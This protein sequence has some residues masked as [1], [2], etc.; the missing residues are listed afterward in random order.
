MLERLCAELFYAAAEYLDDEELTW[1]SH[2]APWVRA[3]LDPRTARARQFWQDACPASLFGEFNRASLVVAKRMYRVYGL[4]EIV[5][6]VFGDNSP[7]GPYTIVMQTTCLNGDL[8]KMQWMIAAC[9]RHYTDICE[10]LSFDD[11]KRTPLH[12]ACEHGHLNVARW[13]A[14]EYDG[15]IT[16]KAVRSWERY[17]GDEWLPD[18]LAIV[19]RKDYLD[20]AQWLVRRFEVTAEELRQAI[21][22]VHR[23]NYDDKLDVRQIPTVR[24]LRREYR[25]RSGPLLHQFHEAV[26]RSGQF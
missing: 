15:G 14:D 23:F 20:I 24:W 8:E 13:L 12:Q 3:R 26:A 16:G 5:Y 25:G 4:P 11:N 2:T 7:R 18:T 17:T 10:T 9:S 19:C 21:D 1:L 6:S 22:H